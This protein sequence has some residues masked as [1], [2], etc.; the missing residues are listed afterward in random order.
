MNANSVPVG[1]R[2]YIAADMV[3][4]VEERDK[5]ILDGYRRAGF[6]YCRGIESAG[7]AINFFERSGGYY[8]D[9]GFGRL[10]GE[11]KI[12]IKQGHEISRIDRHGL[13]FDD[14]TILKADEIIFAT[15]YTGV[16]VR[17]QRIFGDAVADRVGPIW[18]LDK[19]GEVQG[20]WRP[21]GHPG[22]WIAAGSFN[23]ARYYSRLLALQIKAAET[24][25][26][27]TTSS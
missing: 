20:V 25:R 7:I 15:G 14:G 1:L 12:K 4:V 8:I 11:G 10:I 21:T 3:K 19:E 17:T 2:K 27:H 16:R 13:I 6:K 18:G 22:F 23:Y 24:K 9:T 26:N 5:S